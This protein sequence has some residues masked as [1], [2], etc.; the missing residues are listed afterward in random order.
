MISIIELAHEYFSLVIIS[1]GTGNSRFWI[2]SFWITAELSRY[3]LHH[4]NFSENRYDNIHPYAHTSTW[5]V[6][7]ETISSVSVSSATSNV[8][9]A[10]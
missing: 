10:K 9:G 5:V 3:L 4:G 8:S 7:A 2:R 6:I 1:T